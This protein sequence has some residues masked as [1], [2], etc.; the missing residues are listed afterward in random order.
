M[1]DD[2]ENPFKNHIKFRRKNIKPSL[3]T[4]GNLKGDLCLNPGPWKA[5]SLVKGKIYPLKDTE[6]KLPYLKHNGIQRENL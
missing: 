6:M 3:Y 1:N 2:S 5:I 4:L